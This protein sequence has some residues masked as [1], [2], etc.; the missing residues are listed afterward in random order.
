MGLLLEKDIPVEIV[1]LIVQQLDPITLIS[2]SQV[3]QSW[4]TLISPNRHD[5]VRRLLAL[6]LVPEHAGI[7]PLFDE[8]SQ[9]LTPPCESE[10]WKSVKYACCG[11]MKLLTHMMFDNPAIL[12]RPYRKPPPGT[13]EAEK[14]TVTDW[15]RL[16]PSAR[17]RRIQER[18]ARD[19]EERKKWRKIANRR[20]EPPPNPPAHPFARVPRPHDDSE[21]EALRYLVGTSRQKRRC[22]EC[23]RRSGKSI[24]RLHGLEFRDDGPRL[25]AVKSRNIKVPF[26][27]E[28]LYP[29]LLKPPKQLPR[30]WRALRLTTDVLH[31]N[32]YAI[33]C[34]SC[35]TW[36]EYGAMWEIGILYWG[37]Q[38][39]NRPREPFLC[40][41]CRLKKDPDLLA[42]KVNSDAILLIKKHRSI[43]DWCIR[44][45]WRLLFRDFRSPKSGLSDALL[46]RYKDVGDK[47][48]EGL[49]L[50]N[51]D[52]KIDLNSALD[53]LHRRFKDYREFLYTEVDPATRSKI[54]DGWFKPWVEDYE[55]LESTY[56]WLG[57]QI[58]W[59]ENNERAVLDYLLE[60]DP[61]RI[62]R[63]RGS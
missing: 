35:E 63:R 5:Y 3:S 14:A 26:E 42:K 9:K 24:S 1:E 12:R 44:L 62:Q 21:T 16:E 39:P 38:Y 34:P 17:W 43:I 6:E 47:L 29:G 37:F 8:F 20:H 7:V 4:R 27:L 11:C 36:Q 53:D 58:S 61:H 33:F 60:K 49:Q 40:N 57:E 18:A 25:L 59:L 48:R 31:R 52:L 19:E 56:L 41:H 28:R 30:Y 46:G 54:L 50:E 2:L 22:I 45:G 23:L 32:L 15:E 55:L 13:I 51:F 10:E